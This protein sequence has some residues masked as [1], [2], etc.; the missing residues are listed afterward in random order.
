MEVTNTWVARVNIDG[1]EY[2][3]EDPHI[4]NDLIALYDREQEMLLVW[5]QRASESQTRID[6]LKSQIKA[7]C[8]QQ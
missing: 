4:V 8:E 7:L 5:N 6:E 2:T 3:F 1:V